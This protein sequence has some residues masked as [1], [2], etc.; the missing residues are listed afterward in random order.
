[1][2]ENRIYAIRFHATSNLPS[3]NQAQIRFRARTA[4]FAWSQKL[5]L[6]GAWAIGTNSAGGN[7]AIAQQAL[8]GVGS[9]NPV[10][11][12]PGSNGGWYTMVMHSP[13]NREI[14]G[15][16]PNRPPLTTSMPNLATQDAPGQ[17]NGRPRRDIN[18]GIDI[19]DSISFGGPNQALE[20]GQVLLDQVEIHS[21]PMGIN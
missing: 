9:L 6:G 12:T 4:K 13:L 16:F 17:N 3:T 2:E 1:V 7:A 5:E 11:R 19:L 20:Q 21:L 15:D 18:L 10:Q 8:P 14:R